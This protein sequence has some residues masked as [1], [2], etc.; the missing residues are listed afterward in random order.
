MHPSPFFGHSGCCP[1]PNLM[2]TARVHA[3]SPC[4][5]SHSS[6]SWKFWLGWG[7]GPASPPPGWRLRRR[8]LPNPQRLVLPVPLR[9]PLPDA[10]VAVAAPSQ[11]ERSQSPTRWRR[12]HPLSDGVHA[13][14]VPAS[15]PRRR[16]HRRRPLRNGVRPDGVRVL[17]AGVVVAPPP[18]RSE[19]PSRSGVPL[20]PP[21]PASLCRPLPDERSSSSTRWRR[22]LPGASAAVATVARPQT[23]HSAA[24]TSS[25][26]DR[27]RFPLAIEVGAEAGARRAT[28]RR[29]RRHERG[30]EAASEATSNVS[31][32]LLLL[33]PSLKVQ[34]SS[35]KPFAGGD[36][37][38][39][40]DLTFHAQKR[41]GRRVRA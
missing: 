38:Q 5:L 12:R 23:A 34:P 21:T 40:F 20:R 25:P 15:P 16:R 13:L 32:Y 27:D 33:L 6:K 28:A 41:R 7:R 36:L 29:A 9:L 14:P 37:C 22:R 8:P 30:D 19:R 2:T 1:G 3:K 4:F 39:N 24:T 11:A 26:S 31:V 18:R 17:F 35:P 10:G